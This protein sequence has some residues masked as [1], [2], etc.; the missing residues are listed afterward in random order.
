[1]E[2]KK[3]LDRLSFDLDYDAQMELA[4]LYQ[5]NYYYLDAAK[6]YDTLVQKK[7]KLALSQEQWESALFNLLDMYYLSDYYDEVIALCESLDVTIETFNIHQVWGNSLFQIGDTTQAAIQ[8]NKALA[9]EPSISLYEDRIYLHTY[10]GDLDE[11]L[12]DLEKA[13][14]L[15]MSEEDYDYHKEYLNNQ[16]TLTPGQ[17]IFKFLKQNY[18]YTET[19]EQPNIKAIERNLSSK[20]KLETKDFEAINSQ[21][22]GDDYFS[23]I[24]YDEWFSEVMLEE[25]ST[26]VTHNAYDDSTFYTK[27]DFFSGTTD[28]EFL[29]ALKEIPYTLTK[30]L[31]IDLRGNTGGDTESAFNILDYL[32]NSSYLGT[33]DA[34]DDMDY[35]YYSDGNQIEFNHI[36]VLVDDQSASS[37]EVIAL[38]LSEYLTNTTIIGETTF[39]KGVGQLGLLNLKEEF[40]LYAVNAYWSI[41]EKN[42]HGVGIEPDIEL[43]DGTLED[44]MAMVSRK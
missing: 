3:W 13:Y 31:V 44:Y 1:V 43:I 28:T 12:K 7:E 30:K 18:M 26:T 20:Q 15:G 17:Q 6:I 25:G 34:L 42:I 10:L 40:S 33:W 29:R 5:Y 39:G 36:Y 19:L 37:S 38:G 24:L 11:A 16:L 2:A 35:D 14:E 8:L 32:I 22:F 9:F 41:H 4:N 21:V 23:F 27:I